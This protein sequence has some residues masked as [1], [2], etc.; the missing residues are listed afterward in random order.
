MSLKVTFKLEENNEEDLRQDY[1]L[2]DDEK[3]KR[4]YIENI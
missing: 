2:P 4:V 1:R 3:L